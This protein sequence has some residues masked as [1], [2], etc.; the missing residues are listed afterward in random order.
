MT[1]IPLTRA[2][3]F[4]RYA[5]AITGEKSIALL[6]SLQQTENSALLRYDS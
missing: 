1:L 5:T 4:K 3:D 6:I 2:L